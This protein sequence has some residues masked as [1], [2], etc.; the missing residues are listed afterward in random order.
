MVQAAVGALKE[1]KG[2][3]RQAIAKYIKGNYKVN[4]SCDLFVKS[5]LVKEVASGKLVQVPNPPTITPYVVIIMPII[6]LNMKQLE[7]NCNR[8]LETIP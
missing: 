4:D 6:M 3:S 8:Q 7:N 5:T 1:R 2:S